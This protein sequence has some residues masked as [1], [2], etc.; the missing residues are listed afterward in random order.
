MFNGEYFYLW[1][2]ILWKGWD[3]MY[4]I[5][6]VVNSKGY[7]TTIT[8]P[9]ILRVYTKVLD[10]WNI[11]KEFPY[12]I[13]FSQG[14]AVV[15]R[16][17]AEVLKKLEDCKIFVAAEVSGQLY[18]ILEVNGFTSYEA[19]GDPLSFLDSM[20]NNELLEEAKPP[21][22]KETASEVKPI[23]TD[24]CGVYLI[25]LGKALFE[26]SDLSSKKI[27]KPILQEG[28]F[29]VLNVYCDHVPRWFD[30]DLKAMGFSQEISK[31]TEKEYQI[32]IR[33]N[34]N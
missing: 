29:E 13:D 6:V 31:L 18:Y 9:G 33:K 28:K 32:K 14:I 27:L 19:E 22:E 12:S 25:N 8:E 4:K 1:F 26:N 24:Q 16:N 15:K 5:A 17:I 2:F 3:V 23:L 20:Y 10:T 11:I 34:K 21:K 7:T 30:T